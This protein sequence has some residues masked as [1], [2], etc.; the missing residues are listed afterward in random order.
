MKH[1]HTFILSGLLLCGCCAQK[2]ASQPATAIDRVQSGTDTAW[3]HGVY[4]LHV[5]KRQGS[6]LEGVQ[7][8]SKSANGV[9]TIISADTGTIALGPS[10]LDGVKDENSVAIT[11]KKPRV[12]PDTTRTNEIPGTTQ[13][14]EIQ[15]M[16]VLYR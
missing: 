2:Q 12:Q 1:T 9:E 4:V 3:N 11:L 14:Q 5:T 6:S 7:I 8:I 16:R 15:E 13:I 10:C